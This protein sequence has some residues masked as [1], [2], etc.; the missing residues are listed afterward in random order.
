[1][2]SDQKRGKLRSL[3]DIEHADPLGGVELVTGNGKHVDG[4]L[5]HVDRDLADRLHRIGV[6]QN[7]PF[8]GQFRRLLHGE[9]DPRFIVGPHEADHR[10]IGRQAADQ[11]FHVQD[12]VLIH[13]QLRHPV[14]LTGEMGAEDLDGGVLDPAGHDMAPVRDGSPGPSGW[15]RCRSPCR[16]W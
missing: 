6:E 14:A 10:R 11:L 4:V 1:M 15:R 5:L 3:A 9:D 16:N 13:G 7:A 12:A 8:M 2:P